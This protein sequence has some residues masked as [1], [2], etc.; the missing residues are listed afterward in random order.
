MGKGEGKGDLKEVEGGGRAQDLKS[1]DE[2][3]MR[4]KGDAHDSVAD[5]HRG[6]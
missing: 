6:E 5:L 2:L 3:W 4:D 1:L